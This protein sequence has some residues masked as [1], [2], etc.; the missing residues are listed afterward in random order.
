MRGPVALAVL[1]AALT[2]G[3]SAPLTPNNAADASGDSFDVSNWTDPKARCTESA[4]TPVRAAVT[5]AVNPRLAGKTVQGTAGGGLDA[6]EAFRRVGHRTGINFRFTGRT[7]EIPNNTSNESWSSRQRV[8]P[9]S[10]WRGSTSR[11]PRPVPT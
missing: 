4:G 6:R 8:R 7:T 1:A 3:L 11:I 2:V 9:R 10:S 5:Y